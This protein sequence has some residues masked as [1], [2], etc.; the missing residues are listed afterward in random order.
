MLTSTAVVGVGYE[1]E[2]RDGKGSSEPRDRC[3]KKET[4]KTNVIEIFI[5]TIGN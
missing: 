1:A 4:G 3:P 2:T 5:F